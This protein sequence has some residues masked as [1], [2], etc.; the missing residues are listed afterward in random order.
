LSKEAVSKI[1]L[2]QLKNMT[3]KT[4]NIVRAHWTLTEG[5]IHSDF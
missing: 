1:V 4:K 5:Y 2:F 3:E